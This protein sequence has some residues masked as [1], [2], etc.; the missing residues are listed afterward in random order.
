V[1]AKRG[2]GQVAELASGEAQLAHHSRLVYQT[3]SLALPGHHAVQRINLHSKLSVCTKLQGRHLEC[4]WSP[5]TWSR[6][7][8]WLAT[9]R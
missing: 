8:C 5:L 9:T 1:G 4:R 6:L 2:A 3:P 7:A